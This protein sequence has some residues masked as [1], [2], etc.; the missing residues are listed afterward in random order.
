MSNYNY[1]METK[2]E[3]ESRLTDKKINMLSLL[4]QRYINKEKNSNYYL[5]KATILFDNYSQG[6]LLEEI[7]YTLGITRERVRQIEASAL[8]KIKHPNLNRNLRKYL[9]I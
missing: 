4:E 8:H 5:T 9:A 6:L 7:A 2:K 1:S 3:I